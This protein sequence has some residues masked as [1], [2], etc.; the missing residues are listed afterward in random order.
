[1]IFCVGYELFR[2]GM[3]HHT[4]GTVPL[5]TIGTPPP[6]PF[7][8]LLEGL[9]HVKAKSP[10]IK[11]WTRVGIVILFVYRQLVTGNWVESE[12][13]KSEVED[14]E[15]EGGDHLKD[16][17]Y[18]GE[19]SIHRKVTDFWTILWT[20]CTIHTNSYHRS[21]EGLFKKGPNRPW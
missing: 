11:V 3:H 12:V 10:V 9:I 7:S 2:G 1:M 16:L 5:M 13:E 17:D 6:P 15:M 20:T 19:T 4:K 14:G 8:P 21:Q 18:M